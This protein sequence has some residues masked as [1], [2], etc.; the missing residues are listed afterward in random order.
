MA[1]G[2]GTKYI[3]FDG[4][5][6]NALHITTSRSEPYGQVTTT[7]AR[8]GTFYLSDTGGR[9][10]SDDLILMVAVQGDLPDD[11]RIHVRSSGYQWEPTPVL[12][13]PPSQGNITYVEGA[14]DDTFDKSDFIYGPQAWKPYNG[15]D[16]PIY[17]GQDMSDPDQK[18]RFAFIDLKAGLLGQNSYL[19][20]LEDDGMIRV[21]Y[22]IEGGPAFTVFNTYAWC[23]QSNQGMGISWTNDNTGAGTR[24]LGSNGFM[25]KTTDDEG[26]RPAGSTGSSIG[27]EEKAGGAS[28][29]GGGGL[30]SAGVGING[31][32]LIVL[33]AGG[34]AELKGEGSA[35]FTADVPELPALPDATISI[36]SS[37]GHVT[38]SGKS[39]VPALAVSV[40]GLEWKAGPVYQ[41]SVSGGMASTHLF[42]GTIREEGRH[43][44]KVRNTGLPES[45]STVY[46]GTVL[47]N[48]TAANPGDSFAVAGGCDVIQTT[49]AGSGEYAASTIR[50]TGLPPVSGNATVYLVVTDLRGTAQGTVRLLMNNREL[51]GIVPERAPQVSVI[52]F[53]A[54]GAIVPG[55]N[56][57]F[58][59]SV[60]GS[61]P[62]PYL[63]VRNAILAYTGVQDR[64]AAAPAAE[65]AA[66]PAGN[67]SFMTVRPTTVLVTGTPTPTPT[68]A[69]ASRTPVAGSP[70]EPGLLDSLFESFLS[71]FSIFDRS[72]GVAYSPAPAAPSTPAP[73]PVPAMPET[74]TGGKATI[75]IVSD[76]AGAAIS[77]DGVA[78][79]RVTPFDAAGISPGNHTVRLDLEGYAPAEIPVLVT[80]NA[81]LSI[82]LAAA[83]GDAW[84]A[85]EPAPAEMPVQAADDDSSGFGGISV[86][87][88]P[89]G[90]EI[91]LDGKELSEQTPYVIFGLR[92]GSHTVQVSHDKF[93]FPI[94]SKNV[95]V[96]RG[97]ITGVTFDQ[98][99]DVRK[100]IRVESGECTGDEFTVNG[101]Y[102]VFRIPAEVEFREIGSFIVIRHNGSYLS[103]PV[104][105]FL[106]PGDTLAVRANGGVHPGLMVKTVPPGADL[107]VDGF[108]S[109]DKTPC[110]VM[111]LS[112]GSHR[113]AV[114]M[115]GHI[116]A[117]RVVN[118]MDDPKKDVDEEILL[119][120]EDYATG[121]LFV[122]S[123]PPGARI[124]LDGTNTD[125][126]TPYTFRYRTIGSYVLKV[127]QGA[128]TRT[129]DV[130]IL[131]DTVTEYRIDFESDSFMTDRYPVGTG[132]RP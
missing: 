94:R 121:E 111:N 38:P 59:Q 9:G 129:V 132:S 88:V 4:G 67:Y 68:P 44:V 81:N 103:K 21:E 76:P 123:T 62:G 113:I 78:I 55:E 107:L 35:T 23:N 22:E 79:G 1:H 116:P 49:A 118:L 117:E 56:A 72:G 34:P 24:Q 71:L 69:A 53:N 7:D 128:R 45:V 84:A 124:Y 63:E 6:L 80:G 90:A 91:T 29:T 82:S 28:G 31:I 39:Q 104:S 36:Y 86:A 64:V 5:G 58:V 127:V 92:D 93:S 102:P 109:A 13:Q 48:G 41:D 70:K 89:R 96:Y 114:S 74:S 97:L 77:I 37:G 54:S 20:G 130:T 15:A 11:Y 85:P 12:N 110:L 112:E 131:P 47:L 101:R 120:L 65:N 51:P 106:N 95:W 75:L 42:A 125:R 105:D 33:L 2:G 50:F 60:P 30:S 73:T 43:T 83:G 119:P 87:S 3:K 108:L 40:D 19:T 126:T 32:P 14:I 8:S 99:T 66:A 52:P 26:D 18:F 100:R 25:V 46:G 122:K 17:A 57:L 115:L 98:T 10:F 27:Y 16:Y 61:G